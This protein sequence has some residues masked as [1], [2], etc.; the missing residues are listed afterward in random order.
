MLDPMGQP[1]INPIYRKKELM[2]RIVLKTKILTN[3]L[4]TTRTGILRT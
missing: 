1:I 4:K 3:S 2:Y